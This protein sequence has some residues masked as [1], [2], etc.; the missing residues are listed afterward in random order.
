MY[1]AHTNPRFIANRLQSAA[2]NLSLQRQLEMLHRDPTVE[3][4]EINVEYIP[5]YAMFFPT[6]LQPVYQLTISLILHSL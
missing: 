2:Y 5:H 4:S 1:D 3:S 6:A